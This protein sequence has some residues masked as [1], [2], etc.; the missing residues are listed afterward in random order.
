MVMIVAIAE[1]ADLELIRSGL[2]SQ[3]CPWLTA[4]L[5]DD[6]WRPLACGPAPYE[7]SNLATAFT[8]RERGVHG[9]YSY[10]AM[11]AAG[12][13]MP[14]ILG[15]GDV[16][17]P[18]VWQWRALADLRTAVINVQ[19]THPPQPL[20][21]SMLSYLMAQSLR[22]SYPPGLVHA[23]KRRGL[24]YAHDVSV[25]YRGEAAASFQARVLQ[26]AAYQ[27]ETAIALA[28]EHDVLIVN[29]TLIDR[30]C[31][32]LWRELE[33]ADD[34]C[35]SRVADAYGFVDDALAMLDE[36]A[37][38]D[39]ML[40]FSEIGFGPL[41]RFESIDDAL[42]RAGFQAPESAQNGV[43]PLAREAPQGSHGVVLSPAAASGGLAEEVRACLLAARSADGRPLVSRV[44]RREEIYAGPALALAPD[45]ILYPADDRRP[46]LGDPRWA[47]HVNRHLQTGWHRDLGFIAAR[48]SGRPRSAGQASLA[49]IAPTIVA[50][51]GRSP[52]GW[53]AAPIFAAG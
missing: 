2:L 31:H 16:R 5:D 37:G 27:L 29:L 18:M 53:C 17:A 46:P 38:D 40:V 39:P 49:A 25:F 9:C 23:L 45:L 6:C 21:G 14:A 15:S 3:R 24:R 51:L 34:P 35:A 22:Y 36:L 13:A 12:N 11:R 48:R 47:N 30:V 28:R 50:M 26:V 10:W 52:P 33:T 43:D 4:L 32:F 41:E 44:A 19:L 8:G 42:V 20:N 1:G 7:P